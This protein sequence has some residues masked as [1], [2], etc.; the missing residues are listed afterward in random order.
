MDQSRA[1]Y[2]LLGLRAPDDRFLKP[3]LSLIQLL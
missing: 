3:I 2:D 1:A